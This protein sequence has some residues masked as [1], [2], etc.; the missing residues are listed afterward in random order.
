M[1][2]LRYL[3][4]GIQIEGVKDDPKCNSAKKINVIKRAKIPFQVDVFLKNLTP[5]P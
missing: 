4:D 1:K 2:E 3:R 5:M